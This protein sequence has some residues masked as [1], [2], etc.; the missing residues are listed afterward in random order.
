MACEIFYL[1]QWKLTVENDNPDIPGNPAFGR[2]PPKL[3]PEGSQVNP[4]GLLNSVRTGGAGPDEQ[5]GRN[6][7]FCLF[8]CLATSCSDVYNMGQQKRTRQ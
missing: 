3:N 6:I 1:R 2:E 4:A 5:T 7:V 8:I